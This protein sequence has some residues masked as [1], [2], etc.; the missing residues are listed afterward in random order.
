MGDRGS[1]DH[2]R[3]QRPPKAPRRPASAPG[4][5][6]NAGYWI[7]PKGGFETCQWQKG[8]RP[9]EFGHLGFCPPGP[10]AGEAVNGRLGRAHV[11]SGAPTPAPARH[12]LGKPSMARRDARVWIRVNSGAPA[13]ARRGACAGDTRTCHKTPPAPR[14]QPVLRVRPIRRHRR[15][16]AEPR[17][18]A[19]EG[20]SRARPAG[21]KKSSRSWTDDLS[22][23][24]NAGPTWPGRR[25]GGG[26]PE[27]AA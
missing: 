16:V 7:L 26:R 18:L 14:G 11:N 22:T 9:C 10:C 2:R 27:F 17:P 4:G 3:R 13:P 5:L 25:T 1:G 23:F 6:W 19:T 21:H 24:W 20:S 8:T 12:A 15:I